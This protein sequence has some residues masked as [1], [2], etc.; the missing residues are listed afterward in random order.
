M[1][2]D[3]DSKAMRAQI[4]QTRKME[5]IGQLA[6]GIAHDLNNI[7]TPIFGYIDIILMRMTADDKLRKYVERVL[8]S[9]IKAGDLTNNLLAL[10][11]KQVHEMKPLSLSG[12]VQEQL[13]TMRMLICE[14]IDLILNSVE[15]E[16]IILADKRQIEQVLINLVNYAR[17][18]ILK[19]GA[20]TV[21]VFPAIIEDE[22]IRQNGYGEPGN[23]ACL[24]VSDSGNGMNETTRDKI[25]EP[26]F[27]NKEN[28]KCSGFELAIVYGI[29]KQHNGFIG[30]FSE[31]GKGTTFQVYLPVICNTMDDAR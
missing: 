9:A 18:A 30:V 26:F 14:D 22:F 31:E 15:D 19:S 23:Y 7:L 4:I 13:N 27:T 8:D 24:S 11:G 2:T 16:L 1:C 3:K 20:V 28:G 5:A 6:G 21:R 17:D 29:V 10:S 25:F 12:F